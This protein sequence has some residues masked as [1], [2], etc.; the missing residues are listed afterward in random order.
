MCDA[1]ELPSAGR[2][3]N[4]VAAVKARG[5]SNPMMG[6][7]QST[8]DDL[9]SRAGAVVEGGTTV[10]FGNMAS[11]GWRSKGGVCAEGGGGGS[12]VRI[13]ELGGGLG[14][15]MDTQFSG[16]MTMCWE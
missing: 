15:D 9:G 3:S 10:P 11:S 6:K 8:S 12:A 5:C 7:Y 2:P 4:S 1:G 14:G 13:R 16:G